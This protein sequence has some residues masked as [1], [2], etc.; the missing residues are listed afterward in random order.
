MSDKNKLHIVYCALTIVLIAC[1][2]L[3]VKLIKD[4][5]I[6]KHFENSQISSVTD[7]TTNEDGKTE[8]VRCNIDN[9]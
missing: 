7:P 6:E 9:R 3:G 5:R 2:I 1:L 4:N 8:T